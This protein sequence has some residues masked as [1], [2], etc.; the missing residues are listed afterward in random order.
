MSRRLSSK[1]IESLKAYKEKLYE[2]SANAKN[3]KDIKSNS[4]KCGRIAYELSNQKYMDKTFIK[5]FEQ[6][7]KD[8]IEDYK[9]CF[10]G[11]QK[12]EKLSESGEQ[13][14]EKDSE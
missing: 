2:K 6:F 8:H 14:Q 11:T 3:R 7:L 13:S 5:E 10:S 4:S 9:R 1:D 12:E